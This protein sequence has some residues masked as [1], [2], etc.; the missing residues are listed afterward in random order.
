M[1]KKRSLKDLLKKLKIKRSSPIG[2]IVNAIDVNTNEIE[3]QLSRIKNALED[4]GKI[5]YAKIILSG[6][7]SEDLAKVIQNLGFELLIYMSESDVYF[8]LETMEVI[9]NP[10]L[11]IIAIASK[12]EDFIPLLIKAKEKGKKNVAINLL[13]SKIDTSTLEN[14][15]DIVID[16]NKIEQEE[17]IV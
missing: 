13:D 17:K 3:I 6:L 15:C 14:I 1:V 9:F 12:N 4:I 7:G 5:Q 10:K 16:L 8:F 11:E 2:V